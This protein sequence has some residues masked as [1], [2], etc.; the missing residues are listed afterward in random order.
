MSDKDFTVSVLQPRDVPAAAKISGDA[1]GT[2]RQTQM[3]ELGKKPFD[4]TRYLLESLPGHLKHPRMVV[5]KAV[6]NAT[7]ELIGVCN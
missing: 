7:G 1:F 3:K 2:D 6:D 4:T 5:L